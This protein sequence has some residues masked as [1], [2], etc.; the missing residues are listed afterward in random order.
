MG[1]LLKRVIMVALGVESRLADSI[2][3]RLAAHAINADTVT[4]RE[5]VA[6]AR[7]AHADMRDAVRGRRADKAPVPPWEWRATEKDRKRKAAGR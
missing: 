2:Q 3:S 7:A 1:F 4:V 5:Y 6:A